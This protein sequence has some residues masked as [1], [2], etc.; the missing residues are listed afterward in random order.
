[1]Y[2]PSR[3]DKR[4]EPGF[5]PRSRNVVGN[6]LNESLEDL[7]QQMDLS[8]SFAIIC[9]KWTKQNINQ[10]MSYGHYQ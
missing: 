6:F 2:L 5:Y 8:L 3:Q 7:N 10:Y 4:R 1:M 9:I